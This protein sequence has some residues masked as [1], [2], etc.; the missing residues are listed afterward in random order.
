MIFGPKEK[1]G[2]NYGRDQML[3]FMEELSHQWDLLDFKPAKGPYT[4]TNNRVG[5]DH[6]SARLDRFLVQGLLLLEKML[7]SSKILPKLTS[8][9]KPILLL[10]EEE[11]NLGPLPF[12]YSPLWTERDR[13]MEV[14]HTTS[15]NHITGSPS[16][17]W[18]KKLKL[19]KLNLKNLY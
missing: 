13:F 9:H 12:R 11:E 10:L 17:V 14:V 6:I 18:E 3:S 19:T 16:Y 8:D 2:G 4:W 1:S 7:I 15:S 5:T